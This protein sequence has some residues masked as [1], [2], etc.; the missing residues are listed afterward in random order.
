[1]FIPFTYILREEQSKLHTGMNKVTVLIYW[2]GW[3]LQS[4]S[5][6]SSLPTLCRFLSSLSK[7]V[8]NDCRNVPQV[9]LRVWHDATDVPRAPLSAQ[10]TY[11]QPG[12]CRQGHYAAESILSGDEMRPLMRHGKYQALVNSWQWPGRAPSRYIIKMKQHWKS[13]K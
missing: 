3:M 11:Y 1:M 8:L 6:I 12:Q 2:W 9:Y 5:W 10:T 13:G 7:L 4:E